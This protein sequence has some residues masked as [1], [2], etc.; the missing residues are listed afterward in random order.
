MTFSAVRLR[1]PGVLRCSVPVQ[2]AR[3]AC[4]EAWSSRLEQI[5]LATKASFSGSN[6]SGQC[7]IPADLGRAWFAEQA[8]ERQGCQRRLGRGEA[9]KGACRETCKETPTWHCATRKCAVCGCQHDQGE[10][11]SWLADPRTSEP[12]SEDCGDGAIF[13]ESRSPVSR[14]RPSVLSDSGVQESSVN[15]DVHAAGRHPSQE[16]RCRSPEF[17]VVAIV[18]AIV[19]Y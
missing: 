3:F 7:V 19:C 2:E 16:T 9:C 10:Y 11:N 13:Q 1:S 8:W 18:V 5:R 15:S 14:L 6:D 12:R 17:D 4:K